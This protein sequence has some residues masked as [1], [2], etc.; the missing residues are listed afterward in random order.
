MSEGR[1]KILEET[2]K[3]LLRRGAI[4]NLRKIV[5]KTHAAD[6]SIVF[7]NLSINNQR[8]L[9][10]MIE[11]YEQRAVLLSELTQYTITDFIE[12]MAVDELLEVFDHM[13][14]DDVA[15]LIADL[16]QD[17][18]DAVLEKMNSEESQ[19]V[20]DLLSYGDDTAGGIMVPDFVA[21]SEEISAKGAIESL[22]KDYPDVEMPFY[23]YVVDVHERLVG[24]VSLRQLVVVKPDT[25][26][27]EFMTTDIFSVQTDVDQEEVARIVAH[28]DILAV[29]VIRQ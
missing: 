17:T 29:P 21:L 15:D 27:K 22:Q 9:F 24:V 5:N 4:P 11:D 25:P 14:S 3:R 26:L 12:T 10:D 16:P 2:I 18:A 7:R 28:Y 8:K 6:L 19:E 1:N 20:E 13:P 23:L